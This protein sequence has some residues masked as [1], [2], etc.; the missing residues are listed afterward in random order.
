MRPVGGRWIDGGG[1]LSCNDFKFTGN[2]LVDGL[3]WPNTVF[4]LRFSSIKIGNTGYI[5]GLTFFLRPAHPFAY[6]V[7]YLL[8]I[9]FGRTGNTA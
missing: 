3:A 4:E 8:V 7:F 2:W 1:S 9:V 6:P 5:G